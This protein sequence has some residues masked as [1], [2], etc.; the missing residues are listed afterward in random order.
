MIIKIDSEVSDCQ[1]DRE[2][3]KLAIV[4]YRDKMSED[5]ELGEMFAPVA[6]LIS[7]EYIDN[8]FGEYPYWRWTF[9]CE[10]DGQ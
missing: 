10:R 2:A 4:Q 8:N 9:E 1:T 3:F 7:K 5:P 6:K